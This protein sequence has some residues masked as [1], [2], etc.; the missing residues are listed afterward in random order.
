MYWIVLN[1]MQSIHCIK[2][3]SLNAN[4][5][6]AIWRMQCD[7][8]TEYNLLMECKYYNVIDAMGWM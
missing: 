8:M 7:E 6:N 4:L 3:N 1:A 5:E 2:Y